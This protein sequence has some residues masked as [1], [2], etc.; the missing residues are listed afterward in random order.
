MPKLER[1]T[2]HQIIHYGVSTFSKEYSTSRESFPSRLVFSAP[3]MPHTGCNEGCGSGDTHSDNASV[4]SAGSGSSKRSGGHHSSSSD[5]CGADG[6]VLT[7]L[8]D[9]NV[10]RFRNNFLEVRNYWLEVSLAMVS[11]KLAVHNVISK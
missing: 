9:F 8:T 2:Q 5:V 10:L 6:T 4:A 3:H 7:S 1:G 11:K